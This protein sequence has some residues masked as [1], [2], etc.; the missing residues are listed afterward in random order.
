MTQIPQIISILLILC[1]A[2]F[3][4]KFFPLK[5]TVRD[6]VSVSLLTVISVILGIFSWMIPLM[7]FPSLKVGFSQLPLILIGFIFGPSWAFLAGLS[8]DILELLSGT[9]AFPFFGFTLNKILI[10]MIPAL[11]A[12]YAPKTKPFISSLLLSL[13]SLGALGYVFTLETLT[14]QDQVI[15]VSFQ[16]KLFVGAFVVLACSAV[17]LALYKIGKVIKF[18]TS[19]SFILSIVLIEMIVQ[20]G[21]TPLWLN[22]MYGLPILV[23]ISARLVKA[24]LM[25]GLNAYLGLISLQ[26]LQKL[27]TTSSK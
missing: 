7:G 5:I 27:R 3:T 8:A 26:T 15:V 10:A 23:S 13:I 4:F 19:Q 20:M 6:L 22:A 9:I 17:V 16:M 24:V 1:L 18:E 11:V 14:L 12:H 2:I 21:L 25:I